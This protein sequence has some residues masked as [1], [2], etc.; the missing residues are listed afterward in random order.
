MAQFPIYVGRKPRNGSVS[1]KENCKGSKRTHAFRAG[2]G[3]NPLTQNL[4]ANKI[5][6][7]L[8][9]VWY[10]AGENVLPWQLY[11]SVKATWFSRGTP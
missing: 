6:V 2:P 11:V 10:E 5:N 1:R 4:S 8:S 7:R 3:V 9:A